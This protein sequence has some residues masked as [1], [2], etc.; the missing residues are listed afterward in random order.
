MT[1]N[2]PG[3]AELGLREA[4]VPLVEYITPD[5]AIL[6]SPEARRTFDNFMWH[7]AGDPY[8]NN[9]PEIRRNHPLAGECEYGNRLMSYCYSRQGSLVHVRRSWESKPACKE[10]EYFIATAHLFESNQP[11]EW[12][13]LE[14]VYS[15]KEPYALTVGLLLRNGAD[16][17]SL[18]LSNQNFLWF[19]PKSGAPEQL[20]PGTELSIK[21]AEAQP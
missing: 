14:V 20:F 12:E 2:I 18:N 13:V 3:Q 7:Y 4:R 21:L 11:I 10:A 15:F 1:Q 16:T 5:Q 6:E 19:N 9:F 8:V 17:A